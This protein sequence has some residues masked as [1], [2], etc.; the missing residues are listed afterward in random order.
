MKNLKDRACKYFDV[1]HRQFR[2]LSY[3]KTVKII[4]NSRVINCLFKYWYIFTW[5]TFSKI[6]SSHRAETKN[7]DV[8]LVIRECFLDRGDLYDSVGSFLKILDVNEESLVR[9]EMLLN[10]N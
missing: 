1:L 2:V 7:A 6:R 3:A 4:K 8:Y 10:K 9:R 5:N